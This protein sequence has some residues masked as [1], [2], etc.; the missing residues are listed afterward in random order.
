MIKNKQLEN[1]LFIDENIFQHVNYMQTYK[2]LMQ[3]SN[4]INFEKIHPFYIL[5]KLTNI[6]S[7]TQGQFTKNKNYKTDLDADGDSHCIYL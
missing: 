1:S 5:T 4:I 6:A 7:Y 2:V 3:Y